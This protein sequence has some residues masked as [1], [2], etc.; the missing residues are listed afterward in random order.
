MFS[1][2][3]DEVLLQ[4]SSRNGDSD[5]VSIMAVLKQLNKGFECVSSL[6][7]FTFLSISPTVNPGTIC[8]ID[9]VK[10]L[11][12]ISNRTRASWFCI[13]TPVESFREP[14]FWISG[15]R[16][17]Q[18]KRSAVCHLAFQLFPI[19]INEFLVIHRGQ[20][21]NLKSSIE[22][23]QSLP[24]K[25]LGIRSYD[26]HMSVRDRFAGGNF[27]SRSMDNGK[28]LS[29]DAIIKNQVRAYVA[30]FIYW[31]KWKC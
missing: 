20:L 5:K 28:H 9:S 30:S 23:Y 12:V 6:L 16:N 24:L 7:R 4:A 21:G 29:Q 2:S 14:S 18:G 17:F 10:Y 13:P 11:K 3:I 19:F 27:R 26:K 25:D 8:G 15:L 31:N 22:D 1:K